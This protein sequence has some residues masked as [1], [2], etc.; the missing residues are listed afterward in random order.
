MGKKRIIKKTT[1]E[2]LREREAVEGAVRRAGEEAAP[3]TRG[4]QTGIASILATW[5]NTIISLTNEK[6]DVLAQS[7]AGAIGFRGTKKSTPF[8]A[9]RVAEA[10]AEKAKKLGV[11]R[12]AV[13]V[14]GIGAGRESAVR[15]LASHGM[16]LTAIRDRTPIPHNGPRPRKPRRV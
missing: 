2:L 13:N 4:P 1:E 3:S 11:V 10:L 14:T 7:S 16:E 9:S 8:A 15:S 12:V 6:G 5:N